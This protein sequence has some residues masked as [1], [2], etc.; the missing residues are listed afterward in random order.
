MKRMLTCSGSIIFGILKIKLHFHIPEIL[1]CIPALSILTNRG[2]IILFG[3][4]KGG[5]L[6]GAARGNMR[7]VPPPSEM[8][9]MV[10]EK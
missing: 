3:S 8:E 6:I 1:N 4:Q 10:V 5:V 7:N 2:N 9:K